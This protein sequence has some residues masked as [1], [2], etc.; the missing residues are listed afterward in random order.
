MGHGGPIH[1]D[2]LTLRL[3]ILC[4]HFQ[5]TEAAIIAQLRT[6]AQPARPTD[7][8]AS[9]LCKDDIRAVLAEKHEDL[10]VGREADLAEHDAQH[11]GGQ[12]AKCGVLMKKLEAITAHTEAL[13][14]QVPKI[15][16]QMATIASQPPRLDA[17]G[18]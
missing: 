3:A 9:S 2:V 18:A 15:A 4:S 16:E 8:S 7:T 12:V 5:L 10:A 11:G 1:L 17:A 6:P 14:S 13:A